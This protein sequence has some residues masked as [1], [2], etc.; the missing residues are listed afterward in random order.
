MCH[1][2]KWFKERFE[3]VLCTGD[4]NGS[5]VSWKVLGGSACDI[6][7]QVLNV[8]KVGRPFPLCQTQR[9]LSSS[10]SASGL[11]VDILKSVHVMLPKLQ[12]R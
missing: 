2:S 6:A 4:G 7:V 3:D 12:V 9:M 8:L 11:H 5:A 10:T 1:A